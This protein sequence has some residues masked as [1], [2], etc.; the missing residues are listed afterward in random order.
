[1]K[2]KKKKM[3]ESEPML[4]VFQARKADIFAAIVRG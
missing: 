3:E 2:E 1:V 4:L